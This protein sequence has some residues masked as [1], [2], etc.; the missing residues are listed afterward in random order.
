MMSNTKKIPLDASLYMKFLHYEHK[1]SICVIRRRYP[2]RKNS[3][4]SSFL[5]NFCPWNL[6][7]KFS[8]FKPQ[9]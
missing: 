6:N 5:N 3:P 1:F 2:E 7:I 4:N 8:V 9:I